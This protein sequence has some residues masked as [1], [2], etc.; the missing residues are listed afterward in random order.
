MGMRNL[1]SILFSFR[2]Q[3]R[4]LN[5][6]SQF[7]PFSS[8]PNSHYFTSFSTIFHH[9]IPN[10]LSILAF[11]LVFGDFGG[12]RFGW[13]PLFDGSSIP[14]FLNLASSEVRKTTVLNYA[15]FTILEGLVTDNVSGLRYQNLFD[16][17]LDMAY[18]A[19]E[20]AGGSSLEIVVSENRWPIVGGTDTTTENMR[21]YNNNLVQHVKGGTLKKPGW[22]IETYIFALFDEANK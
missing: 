6:H 15:L 21:T 17:L 13:I 12:V 4:A 19:L 10:F 18:S 11:S 7:I 1:T 2:A 3:N 16:A 20:K 22:P 9:L 5:K 14:M 8:L